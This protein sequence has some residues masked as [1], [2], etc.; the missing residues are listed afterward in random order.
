MGCR[1]L[2]TIK[3]KNG[4]TEDRVISI[5][6][7]EE[8]NSWGDFHPHIKRVLGMCDLQLGDYEVWHLESKIENYR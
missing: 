1:Y 7:N 6:S 8:L 3:F 4:K 2:M 5:C